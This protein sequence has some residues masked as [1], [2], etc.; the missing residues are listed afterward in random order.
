MAESSTP[1][2]ETADAVEASLLSYLDSLE[3]LERDGFY[4]CKVH[5]GDRDV[6]TICAS[7]FGPAVRLLDF[8]RARMIAATE[9]VR[10]PDEEGIAGMVGL[11][12]D[13]ATGEFWVLI[14]E[15]FASCVV[16]W[17][18]PD[19]AELLH[20]GDTPLAPNATQDAAYR[21]DLLKR[22]PLPVIIRVVLGVVWLTKN[23]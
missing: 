21:G 13:D 6:V 14:D 22:L 7:P 1:V 12:D 11:L 10:A 18:V 3:W 15:T 17:H 23:F 4:R 2:K 19:L 5:L 16:E 20:L 9:I 8:M